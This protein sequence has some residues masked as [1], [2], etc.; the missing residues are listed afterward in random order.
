MKGFSSG[1]ELLE[2]HPKDAEGYHT[3]RLAI[4]GVPCGRFSFP[5]SHLEQF[6][7]EEK[8]AEFLERGTRTM[9]QRYGVDGRQFSEAPR[10]DLM[11]HVA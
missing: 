4:D 2:W 9:L 5:A 3:V 10:D 1:V 11:S 7:T 8:L 6:G